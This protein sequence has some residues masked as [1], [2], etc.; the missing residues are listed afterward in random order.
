MRDVQGTYVSRP[1]RYGDLF[2]DGFEAQGDRQVD[3]FACMHN[4]FLLI[5]LEGA[6]VNCEFIFARFER[7]ETKLAPCIRRRIKP[8][9][10]SLQ[11]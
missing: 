4:Y 3:G 11:F 10:G 9:I 5:R 7:T 6:G 8:R 2:G 1:F